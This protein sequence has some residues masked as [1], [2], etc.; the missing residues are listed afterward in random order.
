MNYSFKIF[1]KLNGIGDIETLE[2]LSLLSQFHF[3][4][5]NFK[6]SEI[7]LLKMIKTAIISFGEEYPEILSAY[8][9]L[10]HIYSE[11]HQYMDALA[12]LCHAL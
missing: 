8:L 11:C 12:T 3:L 1:E 10:G 7:L 4:K 2:C 5:N 6:L 9:N